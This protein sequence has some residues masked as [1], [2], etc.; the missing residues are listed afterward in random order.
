MDEDP[1]SKTNP[2]KQVLEDNARKFTCDPLDLSK[3]SE[4]TTTSFLLV[5][6]W[7]ETG[8]DNE[9]KLAYKKFENGE[10]QFLLITK[11]TKPDGSRTVPDR[12][13]LTEEE[14][15]GRLASSILRV[16]KVRHELTHMQNG[17]SYS[18]KYDEFGEDNLRV[19]EVD[20]SNDQERV[21]FDPSAF[22][23]PLTEVTG[24]LSYYGWR[25][26]GHTN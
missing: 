20:A 8:D 15:R 14:Y 18:L 12:V 17:I 25:I 21:L 13:K 2:E 10:E 3:L 22:P 9:K 16:E 5:T 6:D 24:D 4:G 7:L 11:V 19:L 26:A 1:Q 23:A